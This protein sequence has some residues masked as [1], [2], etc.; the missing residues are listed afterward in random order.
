MSLFAPPATETLVPT[1]TPEKE[2]EPRRLTEEQKQQLQRTDNSSLDDTNTEGD[3]ISVRPFMVP[4]QI[5]IANL[6]GLVVLH[7]HEDAADICRQARP[8]EYFIGK[9]E[10][11][12]E[13][14]YD[15][16]RGRLKDPKYSARS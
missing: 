7:C 8:G 12:T 5:T 6:D 1:A 11:N 3:V 15:V 13:H 10:K 2:D 9:G 16:Y 4:P 14:D